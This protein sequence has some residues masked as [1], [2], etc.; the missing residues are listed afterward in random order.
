MGKAACL[1]TMWPSLIKSSNGSGPS[2]APSRR[3]GLGFQP[4]GR[5]FK[6]PNSQL[7]PHLHL[8]LRPCSFG[9]RGWWG[10]SRAFKPVPVTSCPWCKR[11]R[12]L[13]CAVL[14]DSPFVSKS[15]WMEAAVSA[16][17]SGLS[18]AAARTYSPVC[19]KDYVSAAVQAA[20]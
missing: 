17:I 1:S 10:G 20:F 8:R 19:G 16:V 14:C 9:F 7:V 4:D 13:L 5:R 18:S 12:A 11:G 6:S 15:A 2:S 3:R